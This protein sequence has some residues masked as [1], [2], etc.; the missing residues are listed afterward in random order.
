MI[1]LNDSL[2]KELEGGYR[3]PYD[4]SIALK[5]LEQAATSEEIDLIFSELWNELHHQGDVG[6]A[7]YYSVPH[8][9]RIANEKKLFTYNVFG[10][11]ATIEIERHTDN[12]KLPKEFEEIYLSSIQK[13]LPK[14][15]KE[16]I[17][18]TWDTTLTATV[19]SALA[20]SKGN[21]QMAEA[22]LKM[23]DDD[24]L[25]DFLENY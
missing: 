1:P 13:E 2:W 8:I 7:S 25:K 5:K 20:V 17:T 23:E 3:I 16:I 21:I 24:L 14:L 22:I 19:F 11:V 10:L 12:P 4:A 6:L 18:D 15:I 9:I